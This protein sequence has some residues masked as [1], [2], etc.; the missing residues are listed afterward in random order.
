MWESQYAL[1]VEASASLPLYDANRMPDDWV[2]GVD[3]PEERSSHISNLQ[4]GIVW[5]SSCGESPIA[6]VECVPMAFVISDIARR[7]GLRT[8]TAT[9]IDVSGITTCVPG[10]AVGASMSGRDALVPM[11]M[12][13]LW[14]CCESGE[15]LKFVERG[16]AIV[17]TL[18]D[19]DLGVHEHGSEAPSKMEVTRVQEKDMPQRLR[20]KFA[21]AD[22]DHEPSEQSASRLGTEATSEVD[23]ELPVSMSSDNAAQLA[24]ILLYSEWVGR[25]TYRFSLD[26]DHLDLEVSD[27]IEIPV[28]DETQRV[29]I[30]AIDYSIGGI[31][32]IEAIRDDDGSYVSTAVAAPSTPSGGGLGGP[33][34]GPV[35]PSGIVLL[36][37]PCTTPTELPIISAAVYGLCESWAC[38]ELYVSDDGGVTY[39]RITTFDNEATVGEIADISGP[40]TDPA[41]PGD[42]P[43]YDSG[44]AISVTLFNGELA[45]ITDAQ[46]A[47][48]QNLA[49]IGVD[50]QWLLIQFRTAVLTSTDTYELTDIIWGVQDTR[51]L[52]GTTVI[53]DTFVLL[54]DAAVL[55][56]TLP[57]DSI[58][59]EQQYKIVTCGESLDA[60][61]SFNFTVYGLC[62]ERTCPSTVLSASLTEPPETPAD[63]DAYLLPNDTSLTGAWVGHGGEITFWKDATAS[64]LFCTPAPGRT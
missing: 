24:E 19:D 48:G 34:E 3:Y 14:D 42:S 56:I 63:G 5:Q 21:N 7:C 37:I 58:G 16:G 57:A 39:G 61:D 55:R 20:L 52:L 15:V 46:I 31:L 30:T 50:G 49:A 11:R 40:P 45:S 38:A 44:D 26:H 2:Y 32:R 10:Y 47:A 27:C 54:S 6:S 28:E 23:L 13:G 4:S 60:V 59:V 17:R 18:T 62:W 53:G 33:G 12:Y 8:D 25:N 9:Q 36:D 51:H 43:Q 22:L 35:C 41:M 64:W 1:A 29:R